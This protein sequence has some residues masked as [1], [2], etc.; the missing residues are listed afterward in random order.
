VNIQDPPSGYD[1]LEQVSDLVME[2]NAINF[3]TTFLTVPDLAGDLA[4]DQQQ[5]WQQ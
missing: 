5:G 3:D 1:F 2:G 4:N